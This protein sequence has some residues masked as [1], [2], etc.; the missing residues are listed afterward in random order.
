[1]ASAAALLLVAAVQLVLHGA[2]AAVRVGT[3]TTTCISWDVPWKR[4]RCKCEFRGRCEYCRQ[5]NWCRNAE[6]CTFSEGA[7][8]P[9]ESVCYL[10]ERDNGVNRWR[11][12][13]GGGGKGKVFGPP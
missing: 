11:P 7:C 5:E 1:M 8:S 4:R 12:R 10:E 3:T 13:D 6:C 2:E 9:N